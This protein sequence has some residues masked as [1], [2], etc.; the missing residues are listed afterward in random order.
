MLAL[1]RALN[2]EIPVR[3]LG[4]AAASVG[5]DVPFM[6]NGG[7][8]LGRGRG[9][10][11]TPLEAVKGGH[12]LIVKPDVNVSTAWVYA[13]YRFGLTKHRPRTNLRAVNAVLARFP[14]VTLSFRNDLEDVVCPAYPLVSGVLS[15]LLFE[16][17]C[18]ASMTGS[19]SALY[20]VFEGRDRALRAAERFSVRGF[21][22]SVAEPAKRAVDIRESA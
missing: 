16:K 11:L 12:F 19:G 3:A 22:T 15:E 7:T 10:K 5:S 1:E 4:R 8:M 18:F 14:A 21:F 20:A 6:L 17:P 13:N 2:L 9:E